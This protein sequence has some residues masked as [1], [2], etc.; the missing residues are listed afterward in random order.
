MRI[1]AV[2][3][4]AGSVAGMLLYA[5][6]RNRDGDR[7]DDRSRL[8]V[9]IGAAIGAVIGARLLWWL[10]EPGASLRAILAGKTI[11]GGLLGGLIGVEAAKRAAG[12]RTRTGDLFV[13]PL[14]AAM[15]VGRIGCFA[16]GPADRTHG[17]PSTL[18]WAIAAGDDVLRHPVALYEIAFL[19]LMVPLLSQVR[20]AP[21]DR[22]RLF[23][24]SYLAF[25][26]AIDF[27]KPY[28]APIAAGLS[29]IQWACVAGL[30]YYAA[31][32]VARRRFFRQEAS[33]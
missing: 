28:P 14:I 1:H 22:F 12:I 18:P 11:V 10:G 17:L 13:F 20:G 7:I 9:L 16:A 33:A 26:L 3:E 21:G 4:I 15:I 24:T 27:L 5:Y 32:A 30:L 31:D 19:L 25:R 6:L 8:T 29:A 2:L 23:L